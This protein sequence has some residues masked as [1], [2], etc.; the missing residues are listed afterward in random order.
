[1]VLK[2]RATHLCRCLIWKILGSSPTSIIVIDAEN[3]QR[4]SIWL[5]RHLSSVYPLSVALN[6]WDVAG[7][8]YTN[9]S[10]TP[11]ETLGV[12]L[13]PIANQAKGIGALAEAVQKGLREKP[14]MVRLNGLPLSKRL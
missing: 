8:R 2:P 11:R 7:E 10:P 13:Y 6:C 9:N 12:P 14:I 4:T 5:R 3:L 1:M